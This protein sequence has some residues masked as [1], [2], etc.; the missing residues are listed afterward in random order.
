MAHYRA[1]CGAAPR[2]ADVRDALA[3]AADRSAK[4]GKITSVCE[5]YAF[6]VFFLGGGV[7]WEACP[8]VIIML[9]TLRD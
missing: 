1:F 7:F 4:S 5:F 9:I 3:A 2:R 8:L 6:V